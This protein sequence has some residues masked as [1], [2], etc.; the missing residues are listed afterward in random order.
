MFL[1]KRTSQ[2]TYVTMVPRVGNET[3]RPLVPLFELVK[4]RFVPWAPLPLPQYLGKKKGVKLPKDLLRQFP[5]QAHAEQA[6][7]PGDRPGPSC[8]H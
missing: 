4:P 1:D 6:V 8:Y 3:L 2:V 7:A 5:Q